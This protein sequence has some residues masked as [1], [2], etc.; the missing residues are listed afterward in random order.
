MLTD[1]YVVFEFKCVVFP[2]GP[3][4]PRNLQSDISLA[5]NFQFVTQK[6]TSSAK[7]AFAYL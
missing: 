3:K 7:F 2:N 4:T 5:D 1:L 6:N